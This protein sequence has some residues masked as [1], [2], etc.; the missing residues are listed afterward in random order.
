MK[1]KPNTADFRLLKDYIKKSGFSITDV[2]K[3]LGIT[4]VALNAKLKGEYA[5]T[6]DE[7]LQLK[8]I[9]KLTQ[10]QWDAIF[11]KED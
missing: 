5:F 9:L 8:K 7:A 6:L 10:V 3:A 4:Y 11:N 2:A 1:K